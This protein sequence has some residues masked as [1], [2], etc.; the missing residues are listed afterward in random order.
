MDNIPEGHERC[1]SDISKWEA[2]RDAYLKQW[3]NHCTDCNGAGSFYG[4]ENLGP[5]GEP[6]MMVSTDAPCIT[7]IAN[8]HPVCP[9]CGADWWT[10]FLRQARV[11]LGCIYP[12]DHPEVDSKAYDLYNDWLGTNKPCPDCNWNWGR[13][14]GDFLSDP[15]ECWC[16]WIVEKTS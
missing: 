2:E 5:H 1:P 8:N 16:H 7:C 6:R 3:P 4:T 15:P 11:A 10:N 14:D 9:R 12:L 13:T